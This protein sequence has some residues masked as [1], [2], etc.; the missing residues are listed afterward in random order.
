MSEATVLNSFRRRVAAHLADGTTLKALAYMAFG[1]GGHAP[2]LTPLPPDPD[3]T[4]LGHELLRKP[5]GAL[6]HPDSYSTKGTCLIE[7]SE[8]VG[9]AV[10]EAALVDADGNLV[11]V[12]NFSP[13]VKD[14]DER[15]EINLTM[16]L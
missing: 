7:T 15:Y 5:L 6:T 13:K 1:D 14:A 8:L 11:A 3:A 4:E 12:K 16:K 9:K 2:D 10:S